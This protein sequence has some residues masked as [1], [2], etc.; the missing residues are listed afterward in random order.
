MFSVTQW[1]DGVL[2]FWVQNYFYMDNP[3]LWSKWEY[4]KLSVWSDPWF[5]GFHLRVKTKC[6]TLHFE[7]PPISSQGSK[8]TNFLCLNLCEWS[9]TSAETSDTEPVLSAGCNST[10]M[11]ALWLMVCV[12]HSSRKCNLYIY[13]C[14]AL[15]RKTLVLLKQ[16]NKLVT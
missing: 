6:S 12:T 13:L 8:S 14:S 2:C 9:S 10:S 16:A 11:C 5:I 3:R 4:I 7:T 15:H 1:C